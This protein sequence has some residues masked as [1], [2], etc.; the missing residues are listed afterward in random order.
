MVNMKDA[1]TNA[2]SFLADLFP[3]A[4]NPRLEE[5]E[6]ANDQFWNIVLS[7]EPWPATPLGLLSG[8]NNRLFKLIR[9]DADSGEPRSLKIWKM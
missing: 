5:V 7:Y 1:V 6:L 3:E 4:R 9:V 8:P 2:N